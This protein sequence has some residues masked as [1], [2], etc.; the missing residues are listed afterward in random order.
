MVTGARARC[1]QPRH[2]RAWPAQSSG[3]V[4]SGTVTEVSWCPMTMGPFSVVDGRSALW[5]TYNV[6]RGSDQFWP[7]FSVVRCAISARRFSLWQA[8]ASEPRLR[9]GRQLTRPAWLRSVV[10]TRPAVPTR[11]EALSMSNVTATTS[12]A[13]DIEKV[14]GCDGNEEDAKGLS[15]VRARYEHNHSSWAPLKYFGRAR[16]RSCRSFIRRSPAGHEVVLGLSQAVQQLNS[17]V[18]SHTGGS[19]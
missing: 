16:C 3:L 6:Q 18:V 14:R 12:A 17:L 8:R 19:N 4:V 5:C 11:T 15:V 2:P 7:G 13:K 9:K 1:P 10:T